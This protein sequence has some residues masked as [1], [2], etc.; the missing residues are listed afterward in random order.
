MTTFNGVTL[1]NKKIKAGIMRIRETFI[2]LSYCCFTYTYYIDGLSLEPPIG[3]V[4]MLYNS[5]ATAL[6]FQKLLKM[7]KAFKMAQHTVNSGKF[8]DMRT[9]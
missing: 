5:N 3:D 1:N 2:K 6:V 7:L 4:T 8:R 9:Q